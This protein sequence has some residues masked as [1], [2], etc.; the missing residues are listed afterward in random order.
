M[1][2]PIGAPHQKH[3]VVPIRFVVPSHK[4]T[5]TYGLLC[6]TPRP[7]GPRRIRE[8][9]R[10]GP[11]NVSESGVPAIPNISIQNTNPYFNTY[12]TEHPSPSWKYFSVVPL[13]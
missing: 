13:P 12:N 10:G 5:E 11:R 4:H 3:I 7:I 6:A 1:P 9:G 2:I 8:G